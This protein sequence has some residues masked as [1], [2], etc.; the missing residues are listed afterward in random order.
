MTMGK[1][2]GKTMPVV[3]LV[4]A[5]AC[6]GCGYKDDPVPPQSVLPAAIEDLRVRLDDQ[7][8]RLSWS[9][10]RK[11]V[12]GDALE[13]IDGFSLFQA[14]IPV[15]G[16]CASCPVPYRTV[17]DVAGG[18]IAAEDGRTATY[19]VRG[20]RPGNLYFFKVRSKSGWWRESMDSNEVSFF[21]QIP[22]K[23]PEKLT[24]VG[25]DGNNRLHWQAVTLLEDGAQAT[26]PVL[27]QVYRGVD[28]SV[29]DTLGAPLAGTTYDDTAVTNGR[30]YTYRIQ[31]VN[32]YRYGRVNSGLS[33]AVQAKPADRTPP[34]VPLRVEALRTEIGVKIFWDP[35]EAE[36]LA[37]YRVYRRGPGMS[38]P[39]RI[40]EVNLPYTL[41][42]DAQAPAGELLYSVSSIDT[43]NPANESARS[44]EVQA[45]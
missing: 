25:G 35:V 9:Y 37:G 26:V 2:W 19:E 33:A 1:H 14:E 8:A 17:I 45:E 11:T 16:F 28:G 34:P 6:A 32:S 7:G 4:F 12:T 22:P 5:C 15:E 38:H 44:P 42:V 40:G 13:M 31:A 39:L 23:T 41:L 3:A 36:D 10:P 30:A 27:Y 21:W 20:L 29:P 43:C 18:L 24:V